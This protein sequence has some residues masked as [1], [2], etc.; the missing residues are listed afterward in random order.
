MSFLSM[1][2][3]HPLF[4]QEILQEPLV[5]LTKILMEYLLCPGTQFTWKPVYAFQEISFHFPQSFGTLVHKPCWPSMS[6]VPGAPP[7]SDTSPSMGIWCGA[8]NSLLCVSL[9]DIVTFQSIECP[10]D[11][12]VVTYRWPCNHPS[13]CL[14]VAS[15]LSS[16]VGYLL[17]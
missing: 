4:F 12:Y 2:H 7:P 9:C 11:R 10:S 3:S 8:Q 14:D 1:S 13:Y 6:N 5:G 16:G 15:S 17:W